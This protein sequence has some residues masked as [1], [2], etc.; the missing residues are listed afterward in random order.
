MAMIHL[1]AYN[2]FVEKTS[3]QDKFYLLIYKGNSEQSKCAYQNLNE[4][5]EKISEF[6]IFAV[7]VAE[8]RDIHTKLSVT[9][10]PTLIE[11]EGN[12]MKNL[13]KGCQNKKYLI[14]MFE[15]AV[16]VAQAKKAG[17][18][19]K[20]VT[21]YSTPTCSWCNTLKAYLRKQ[22]IPFTDIDVSRNESAAKEMVARSG[23]QGVPQTSIGGEMVIGFDQQK[24]DRLLEIGK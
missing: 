15:K 20:D 23:Q 8:V 4:L 14:A 11:F 2:D 12:E 7:N 1:S 9:T 13:V 10:A 5:S 24:I 17:K 6:D 22:K 16:F 18:V 21:V 19:I 3:R